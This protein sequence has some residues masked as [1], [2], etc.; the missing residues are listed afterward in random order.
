MRRDQ[1]LGTPG[2]DLPPNSHRR[3][4]DDRIQ[5]T[6][7]TRDKSALV[8][9]NAQE[10]AI[11]NTKKFSAFPENSDPILRAIEAHVFA[12][13]K[14]KKNSMMVTPPEGDKAGAEADQAAWAMLQ[15]EPTTIGGVWALLTYFAQ[16]SETDEQL[17]PEVYDGEVN[18]PAA[19][20]RHAAKAL[21]KMEG[22]R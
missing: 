5:I 16:S 20:A 3:A 22:V 9:F 1:V 21:S 2:R 12:V 13:A 4:V 6:T 7:I 11:V 14:H 19:L 15:V 17:F 8:F 18:Y 10:D